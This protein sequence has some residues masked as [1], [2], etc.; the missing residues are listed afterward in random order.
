M[1]CSPIFS[2]VQFGSAERGTGLKQDCQW[3]KE[4]I[5]FSRKR[6]QAVFGNI[7]AC[8]KQSC[9][10]DWLQLALISACWSPFRNFIPE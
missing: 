3:Q 5:G 4:L 9:S 6:L 8:L 1:V 2:Q 10:F 7:R